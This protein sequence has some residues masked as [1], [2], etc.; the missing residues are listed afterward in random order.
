[1]IA[2]GFRALY[3]ERLVTVN[4]TSASDIRDALQDPHASRCVR[5]MEVVEETTQ[6]AIRS[7]AERPF[8]EGDGHQ[9]ARTGKDGR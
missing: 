8:V 4:P 9:G 7:R 2:Y 1:M 3:Q 5:P 6:S